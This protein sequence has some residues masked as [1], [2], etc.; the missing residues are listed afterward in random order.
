MKAVIFIMAIGFEGFYQN[1]KNNLAQ[2]KK[3]TDP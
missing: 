1:T 3:L 2:A